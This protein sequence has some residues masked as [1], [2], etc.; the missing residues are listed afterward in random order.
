[1][2]GPVIYPFEV[3]D[4]E[5]GHGSHKSP[6]DPGIVPECEISRIEGG[7]LMKDDDTACCNLHLQK[8]QMYP[9]VQRE[10]RNDDGRQSIEMDIGWR[11]SARKQVHRCPDRCS[12]PSHAS[13]VHFSRNCPHLQAGLRRKR[14]T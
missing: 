10:D 9:S 12:T 5:R 7:R 2:E 3:W 11:H 1:M 14:K 8:L 4:W 6:S 13:R